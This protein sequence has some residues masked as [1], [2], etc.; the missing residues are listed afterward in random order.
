M[1]L[2]KYTLPA[3]A[4][5]LATA[6]VGF[7]S[8]AAVSKS[9]GT[10]TSSASANKQEHRALTTSVFNPG[11]QAIFAIFSVLVE[12]KNDAIL[13][14]AQFSAEQARKLVDKI[15]AS[16]KHLTTIYISHGDPDFYFGLDT[17]QAAFPQ[18]KIVATPQTIAHIQETKD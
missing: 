2:S 18:A 5:A 13:I 14:D 12:G 10:E 4:F 16:Q 1:T 15:K 17:L 9:A 3:C 7:Q 11:E 8:H 6:M